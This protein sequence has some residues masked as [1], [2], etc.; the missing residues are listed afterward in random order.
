MVQALFQ[1]S[2]MDGVL[3]MKNRSAG[4]QKENVSEIPL[5][6]QTAEF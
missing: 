1:V 6:S 5:L 3:G 2:V 4:Y